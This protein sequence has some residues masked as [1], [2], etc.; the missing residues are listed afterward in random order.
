[1]YNV[2]VETKKNAKLSFS[3]LRETDIC[4]RTSTLLSD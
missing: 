4:Q 2:E 3:I 1:M